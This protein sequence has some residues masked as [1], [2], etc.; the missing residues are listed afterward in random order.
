MVQPFL[1]LYINTLGNYSE[2]EIQT[3]SGLIFSITF[4]TAF[5]FSPLWGK[6][7]DRFGRK[8]ILVAFAF[9]LSLSLFLMGYVTS[10]FQLFLLRMFMGVFTGFVSMS[11]ALISTQTSKRV[12]GQVLGTLQT[13]SI[14]G[15]LLGPLLGGLLA[16]MFGYSATFIWLSLILVITSFLVSFGIKEFTISE[17]QHQISYTSKQ[18]LI[19]IFKHPMLLIVMLMSMIVQIANFSIQPILSLFVGELHGIGHIAFFSGLALS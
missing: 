9:G 3:W 11:Q 1:S 19:H 18:V 17:D 12:A 14:V 4:V 13:G 15:T 5:I 8:P 16:D 10:I 7:G 2:S 6:I